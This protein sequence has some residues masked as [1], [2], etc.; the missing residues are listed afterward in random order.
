MSRSWRDAV[1]SPTSTPIGVQNPNTKTPMSRDSI[2]RIYSM[3]KPITSVAAM[4][5]VEEG[6]MRL[7]D[8][9]SMYLPELAN[10]RVA[11]NLASASTPAELQTQ[12]AKNPIRVLDLLMHTAGFTYGFFK[13]FPGGG[14]VEQMYIDGGVND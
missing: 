2:F 14:V 12:P 4:T 13:P 3:T 9:V 10:L 7:T 8:P 1:R 11:T 5:L 6:K